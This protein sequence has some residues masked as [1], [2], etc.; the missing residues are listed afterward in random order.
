MGFKIDYVDADGNISNYYP[1]FFVKVPGN[2]IYIVETKGN[3]DLDDPEKLVRL[4]QWCED[5]NRV[6]SDV[7]YDFVFV[8]EE[9]FDKYPPG[10]FQQLVKTFREYKE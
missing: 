2:K 9:S 7:D 1:D 10:S 5:V 8:D 6:Q 4:R 3:E